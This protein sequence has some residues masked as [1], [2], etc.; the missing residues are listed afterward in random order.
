MIPDWP[1]KTPST[2]PKGCRLLLRTVLTA[3]CLCPLLTPSAA[4]AAGDVPASGAAA[5]APAAAPFDLWEIRVLGNSVLEPVAVES[6]V[7]PFLGPARSITDVEAARA[8]LEKTFHD[9][10][11]GTVFVD[12]PEQEVNQGIV[13]LRVTEG[14]LNAVRITGATYFPVQDV[15]AGIPA[16]TAGEVPHLPTLQQ[17]IAGINGVTGDR[18]IAPV[19]KA[20]PVPGTV[21]LELKVE[22]KLPFHG[23]VEVNNAYT[24]DTSELRAIAAVSYDNAFGR[25][26]SA[27]LQYQ[28][29][30]QE[31]SEVSVL[32]AS[33][34]ARLPGTDARLAA[35]YV[36][37]DSDVATVGAL[38]VLGKGDIAG[39]RYVNPLG[40]G[41]ASGQTL[42][43]GVDYKDF[44]ENILL[45][46]DTSVRTP[47]SY[48]NWL[49]SYAAGTRIGVVDLAGEAAANFGIR[50]VGND[51]QEFADKRYR[52]RPNYFYLR[53]EGSATVALPFKAALR[54]GMA[55]QG[56]AEPIIPNEQFAI[57]GSLGPRGYLDAEALGD[58][59]YKASLQVIAPRVSL[60]E[61]RFAFDYY[62]FTDYGLVSTMN[63]LPGEARTTDLSSVGIGLDLWAPG[64]VVGSLAWA[65]PLVDGPRTAEGDSRVH[66]SLRS[67]W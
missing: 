57:G 32:A 35:F 39:L 15:R 8:A 51:S 27:S 3:T 40:D 5:S 16:A 4:P 43:F 12:I 42:T 26:D 13:R 6:V 41:P 10:G 34:V 1:M 66:F 54:V 46:A 33:Y 11:Y 38:G 19:L 53:G 62:A 37:S 55:G 18:R 25:M 31:P 59:G 67:S 50:G 21:D 30:P 36:H 20:G 24:A 56:A 28:T 52:G 44:S 14:R 7:Y 60:F 49:A 61:E 29:S 47:I 23:N 22:D 65:Y 45:D 2:A 9:R 48:V 58:N 17:Q 63:A 64:N